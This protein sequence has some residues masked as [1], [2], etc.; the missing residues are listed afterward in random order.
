MVRLMLNSMSPLDSVMLS[1]WRFGMTLVSFFYC[2]LFSFLPKVFIE[3]PCEGLNRK[4]F[5]K[6]SSAFIKYKFLSLAISF[7]LEVKFTCCKLV[8]F[9]NYNS[10]C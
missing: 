9:S 4:K 10:G 6:Q 1:E 5:R 3:N 2:S 8:F 7:I